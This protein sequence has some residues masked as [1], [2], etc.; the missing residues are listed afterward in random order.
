M[1]S[2]SVAPATSGWLTDR[3]RESGPRRSCIDV[4]LYEDQYLKDVD[5]VHG[6]ILERDALQ[7]Q[8]AW[9]D[10]VVWLV[11]GDGARALSTW[12]SPAPSR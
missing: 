11:V 1:C 3:I 6:N 10:A 8:L 5:F 2:S 12:T 7:P 9:A 4:L